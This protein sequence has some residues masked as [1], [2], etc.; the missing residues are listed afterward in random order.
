MYP[1]IYKLS[2]QLVKPINPW[3]MREGYGSR[4]VSVTKLAATY[5][6]CN[7]KTVVLYNSKYMTLYRVDSA[8]NTSFSCFSIGKLLAIGL[9]H[10]LYSRPD[11]SELWKL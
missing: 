5:L 1:A 6:M 3:H 4:V 10:L 9:I 7:T 2:I 11:R 8:E